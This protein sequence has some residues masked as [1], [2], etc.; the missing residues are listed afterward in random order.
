MR[1][2]W[3]EEDTWF[4]FEV[5][6][7]GCVTR[8]AELEGPELIPVAAASLA[9]WQRAR[10]AGRLGDYDSS[11]GITAELPVSEWEGHEP[12]QLTFEEFEDVWGPARQRI[13]SRPG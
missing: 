1:C 3:D 6:A 9:E 5:D 8:Q 4:N 7:E 13:A 12:E 2:H 10:D 11:F